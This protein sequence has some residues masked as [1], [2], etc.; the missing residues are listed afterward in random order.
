[1]DERFLNERQ[2]LIKI[3][4][5]KITKEHT[6]RQN[7]SSTT[8]LWK[9][10][11]QN[12]LEKVNSHKFSRGFLQK[13]EKKDKK[14]PDRTMRLRKEESCMLPTARILSYTIFWEIFAAL[15]RRVR[16][17]VSTSKEENNAKFWYVVRQ[18]N[19]WP[20][21]FTRNDQKDI[22]RSGLTKA[23]HKPFHTS[24][25]RDNFG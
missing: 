20:E 7:K 18:Y 19:F 10:E 24:D 22:Q 9:R 25:G 23:K 13:K 2:R 15:K 6:K 17:L 8:I 3:K 21:K 5:P 16:V 12:T 11:L 14:I 1:M 4:T